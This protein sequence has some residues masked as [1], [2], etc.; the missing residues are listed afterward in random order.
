[1]SLTVVR[2][3]SR[4]NF[5][6]YEPPVARCIT[7]VLSA[8]F[9]LNCSEDARLR[10]PDYHVTVLDPFDGAAILGFRN[11]GHELLNEMTA[12]VKF[13]I[14]SRYRALKMVRLGVL[15]VLQNRETR[16]SHVPRS[17]EAVSIDCWVI[18]NDIHAE[19]IGTLQSH[20]IQE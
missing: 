14:G 19:R 16:A 10:T 5:P 12:S 11:M 1:M 3:M 9:S 13:R 17:H 7:L 18:Q 6:S 20:E 15:S 8:E 2:R 4:G